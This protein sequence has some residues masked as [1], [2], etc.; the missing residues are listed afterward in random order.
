VRKKKEDTL[1]EL[2]RKGIKVMEQ[3]EPREGTRAE[4]EA[5]EGLERMTK[6]TI[7]LPVD[8]V[9]TFKHKAIDEGRTFQELVAEAMREYLKQR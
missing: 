9:K 1:A 2:G 8:L 4:A 7:R 3:L 5:S 6:V